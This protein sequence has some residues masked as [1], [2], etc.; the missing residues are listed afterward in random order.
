MIIEEAKRSMH[1]ALC[2]V[3]NLVRSNAVVYGGGSA[4]I[5]ASLAVAN[6][7]DNVLFFHSFVR[8]CCSFLFCLGFRFTALN[9]TQCAPLLKRWTQF[10]WLLLKTVDWLQLNRW[11]RS[12]LDKSWRRT[13]DWA[14]TACS[15]E[16]TVKAF[17]SLVLVLFSH[18]VVVFFFFFLFFA[19]DMKT[20][21]VFDPLISKQQ[22]F[23]LATQVVKMILKIDDVIKMGQSDEA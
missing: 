18:F 6:A 3:R 20:Q 15:K 7:A 11:L 8:T 16:P 10:L 12:S 22:Q 9:N 19:I 13:R 1:D 17:C 23:M 21:G 14:L 4:E 5:A 2:V